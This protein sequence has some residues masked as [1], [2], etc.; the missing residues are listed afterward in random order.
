MKTTWKKASTSSKTNSRLISMPGPCKSLPGK[1]KPR[2]LGKTP[3]A[4]R[5]P[6]RLPEVAL[7]APE[8]STGW[9]PLHCLMSYSGKGSP[10]FLTLLQRRDHTGL[11]T[12][13]GDLQVTVQAIYQID[14]Q[15]LLLQL[16]LA[17]RAP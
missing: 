15:A 1:K 7:P 2:T 5:K 16:T 17:D 8:Q 4:K 6:L 9:L 13:F 11:Q 12:P 10:R 14:Q 3:G